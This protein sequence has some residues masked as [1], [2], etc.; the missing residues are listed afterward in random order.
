MYTYLAISS[1]HVVRAR[2]MT[3]SAVKQ[4]AVKAAHEIE[5]RGL[6]PNISVSLLHLI[7]ILFSL[8]SLKMRSATKAWPSG[9]QWL[10]VPSPG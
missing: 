1:N 9:L 2:K 10:P 7:A 5:G 8:N 3:G 6:P 4:D